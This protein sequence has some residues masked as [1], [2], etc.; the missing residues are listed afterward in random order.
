MIVASRSDFHDSIL[1][2]S[3]SGSTWKETQVDTDA[4]ILE[5]FF[6]D[7]LHGFAVGQNGTILKYKPPIVDNVSTQ[8]GLTPERFILH[9]NYPN[10]F[11]SRTVVKYTI[12]NDGF[13]TLD[14][15]NLLGEKVTS[16]I[17]GMKKAGTYEISFNASGLV[18]GIYYYRLQS[19]NFTRSRKMLLL[20]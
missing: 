20:K 13:V 9:Q 12:P 2:K 14:V 1:E 5:I 15:F 4:S 3:D 10:P 19:D 6:Y 17:D 18:S 11:N 8:S 7:S 16:L